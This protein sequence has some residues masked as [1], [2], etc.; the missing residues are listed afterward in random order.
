MTFANKQNALVAR[1]AEIA[2]RLARG[3]TQSAIARDLGV[4][5]A[6]VSHVLSGLRAEWRNDALSD[7]A[8]VQGNLLLQLQEVIRAG[9]A[10][11][12][13]SGGRDTSALAAV[14]RGIE[15]QAKLLGVPDA[16]LS[17]GYRKL[18][19][20]V[21]ALCDAL[22]DEVTD[23]AVL[24]R[25]VARLESLRGGG[26]TIDSETAPEDRGSPEESYFPPGPL[27]APS[28]PEI[29]TAHKPPRT[30]PAVRR[31]SPK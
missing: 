4:S 10:T 20:T 16:A 8:A 31:R 29:E 17:D 22:R 5:P 14:L 28:E 30:L 27:P 9:W 2:R 3:E 23:P 11:Y 13:A 24:A 19:N 21:Q 26:P 25:I 12:D 1:S 7:F 18:A 6:T 15:T